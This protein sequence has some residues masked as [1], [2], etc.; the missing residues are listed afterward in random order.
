MPVGVL[1]RGAPGIGAKLNLGY[2]RANLESTDFWLI[3][4]H[5]G[6]PRSS[7]FWA[8]AIPGVKCPPVPPHAIT[9]F[10]IFL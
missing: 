2:F 7:K 6:Y 9:I 1:I 10:F 5:D 3:K 4:S 8:R